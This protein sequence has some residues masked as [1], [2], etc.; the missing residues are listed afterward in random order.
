MV[1]SCASFSSDHH[2]PSRL[3]LSRQYQTLELVLDYN[4]HN[5]C[6]HGLGHL[7]ELCFSYILVSGTCVILPSLPDCV[8]L[9]EKGQ[10]SGQKQG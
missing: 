8:L 6:R 1:V 4:Q 7:S 10:K 2:I 5:S 9:L 3:R